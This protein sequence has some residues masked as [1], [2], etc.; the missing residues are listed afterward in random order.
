ME[1]FTGKVWLLGDDIDTDIIMP[2]EY[3][4]FKTIDEMKPYAF[5]PLRPELA[6]R[7]RNPERL[8]GKQK[9]FAALDEVIREMQAE[10]GVARRW[11]V[12]HTLRV[13]PEF[14]RPGAPVRARNGKKCNVYYST[15][16]V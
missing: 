11:H 7:V 4:V 3:L 10:G 6:A 14:E 2:T 9:N 12:R 5:S 13:K 8:A 1:K 16:G 15:I